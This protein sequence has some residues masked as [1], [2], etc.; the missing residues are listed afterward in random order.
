MKI[1]LV[2]CLAPGH[3]PKI[4]GYLTLPSRSCGPTPQPPVQ[5]PA[6]PL[7]SRKSCRVFADLHRCGLS[8]AIPE[9]H[10]TFLGCILSQPPA[11]GSLL[12]KPK[13]LQARKGSHASGG[14]KDKPS[15]SHESIFLLSGILVCCSEVFW[16]LKNMAYIIYLVLSTF[17]VKKSLLS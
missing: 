5:G 11:P 4:S 9:A 6:P 17:A 1:K 16:S 3:F 7:S 8:P 10:R 14:K 2:A 12:V 15:S 13:S